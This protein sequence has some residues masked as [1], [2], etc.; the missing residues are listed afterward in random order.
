MIQHLL[1]TLFFGLEGSVSWFWLDAVAGWFAVE[2]YAFDN[3]IFP[4]CVI[5]NLNRFSFCKRPY[6]RQQFFCFFSCHN[7]ILL[8]FRAWNP[9]FHL[10]YIPPI[11]VYCFILVH[12]MGK[13]YHFVLSNQGYD[14][15]IYLWMFR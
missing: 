13:G 12:Y 6:N 9:T 3:K 8:Y 11:V 4:L 14:L 10:W 7:S 1:P 5:V 2:F 15:L